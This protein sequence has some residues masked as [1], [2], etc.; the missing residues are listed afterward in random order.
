[1]GFGRSLDRPIISDYQRIWVYVKFREQGARATLMLCLFAIATVSPSPVTIPIIQSKSWLPA[2]NTC[3]R[4][5]YWLTISGKQPHRAAAPD[6]S[7]LWEH[8]SVVS[9]FW[10]ILIFSGNLSKLWV[11]LI[12]FTDV[13]MYCPP[14]ES[15]KGL[16]VLMW[17]L[18][19]SSSTTS[20]PRSCFF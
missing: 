3:G 13:T 11:V 6:I 14:P 2:K 9:L 12:C 5:L 7:F 16:T 15:V 10:H 17:T 18:M 8:S 20:F 1:M 4:S 19:A